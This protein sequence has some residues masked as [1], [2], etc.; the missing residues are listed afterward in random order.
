MIR[1]NLIRL[2][3]MKYCTRS[4]SINARAQNLLSNLGSNK[5]GR[6]QIRQLKDLQTILTMQSMASGIKN[7]HNHRWSFEN[8]N[9][10]ITNSN[11]QSLEE[12]QHILIEA[13]QILV[14][15]LTRG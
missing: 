10:L 6:E 1:A 11:C 12:I 7:S 8:S 14:A 2:R 13:N 5:S 9:P 15:R 4:N 3:S